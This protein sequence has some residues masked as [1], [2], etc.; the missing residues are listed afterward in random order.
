MV[1]LR[2][3]KKISARQISA[4]LIKPDNDE[5]PGLLDFLM[6][7]EVRIYPESL[8]LCCHQWVFLSLSGR[9]CCRHRDE[10][11]NNQYLL[12]RKN[13]KHFLRYKIQNELNQILILYTSLLP[14][15][16]KRVDQM[17]QQQNIYDCIKRVCYSGQTHSQF[18]PLSLR[19]Y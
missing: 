14:C 11:S 7:A 16:R 1:R 15:L 6:L 19:V 8:H 17:N 13:P 18:H 5:L 9:R 2:I 4:H 3:Q 12:L 10:A